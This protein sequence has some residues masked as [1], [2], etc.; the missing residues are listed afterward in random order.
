MFVTFGLG[1]LILAAFLTTSVFTA[2]SF[3]ALQ[4]YLSMEAHSRHG[5]DVMSQDIRQADFLTNYT[6]TNL[7]F[8]TTDPATSNVYTLSY[9]YNSN[10]QTL[11]RIY[12]TFTNILVSNCNYF[13]FDVYQRNTTLTN[14]GGDLVALISTNQ[15]SLVKAIDLTWMCTQTAFGSGTSSD[16]VQSERV[17]I[18]KD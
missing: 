11:T 5:M 15:P 3:S 4:N 17:V 8:Q 2:R 9:T 16:D 1:C 14:G 18:R 12:G 10:A 13:H 7:T 6:T